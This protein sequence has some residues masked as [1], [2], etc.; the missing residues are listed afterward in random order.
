MAA[1]SGSAAKLL[2]APKLS[3]G[4]MPVLRAIFERLAAESNELLARLCNE[5]MTFFVNQIEPGQSWDILETYED[6]VGAIYHA[7]EWDSRILIGLDRRFIFS[8]MEAAFGGDGSENALETSRAFSSLELRMVK[9]ILNT[10]VP[11][12]EAMFARVSPVTFDFEKLSTPLDFTVLGPSDVPAV[13]VQLLF[14]VQ[15]GGG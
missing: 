5:S 7:A 3:V 14:Q 1:S 11:L 2:E 15:D 9:E 13:Q 10:L 4:R 12:L 8:I 6:S